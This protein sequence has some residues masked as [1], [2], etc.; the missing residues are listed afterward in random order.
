[1]AIGFWNTTTQEVVRSCRTERC[2]CYHFIHTGMD[3]VVPPGCAAGSEV[4]FVGANGES[5]TAIVPDT[6]GPGETFHVEVEAAAAPVWLDALLDALVADKFIA[7]LE[8]F[9][10]MHC[11][12][13]LLCGDGGFSLVHSDV[14][15][16]Y[17]RFYESRMEAYLRREGVSHEELM[18]A[19]LQCEVATG[20]HALVTS[21]CAV[22]DFEAFAK[23][24]QQRA[25]EA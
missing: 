10:T 1:M 14:H 23:M 7:V 2:E 18:G 12:S 3:V 13:F 21:L 19:L 9:V 22:S 8:S 20:K 17:K 4:S 16:K 5:L 11:H 15:E 25:A 6:V 24:M